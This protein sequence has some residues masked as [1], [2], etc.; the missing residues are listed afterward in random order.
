M[1]CI[2]EHVRDSTEDLFRFQRN[3]DREWLDAYSLFF[4]ALAILALMLFFVAPVFHYVRHFF[5]EKIYDSTH[6]FNWSVRTSLSV[7]R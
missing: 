3:R 2:Y 4:R 6:A 5:D 7:S 1:E